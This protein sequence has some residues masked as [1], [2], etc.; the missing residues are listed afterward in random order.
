MAIKGIQ[1]CALVVQDLEK[2]IWFY[3][4]ALGLERIPRPHTFT[5]EG[6]WFRGGVS[7]V[8]LIGANDTTAAAGVDDPGP[9]RMTGLATHMAFEV[10]DLEETQ[11]RFAQ[12][13][14]EIVG[15]P[16]A[17]GDGFVQIW[18]MDPDGHMVEFFQ[19]TDADQ[20][21]APERGAVRG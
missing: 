9:G 14:V 19:W 10:T 1:H 13:G 3:G 7:E 18:L 2:S 17:R 4:T 20:S 5:F 8:H 12:H 16:V 21:N 15:G 6:A 11:S